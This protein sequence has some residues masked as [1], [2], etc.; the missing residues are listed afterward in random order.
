MHQ[1]IISHFNFTLHIF[2]CFN[3]NKYSNKNKKKAQQGDNPIFPRTVPVLAP[4]VS[5]PGNLRFPV[6]CSHYDPTNFVIF[7]SF[8]LC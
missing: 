6:G 7:Q 2:K 5:Y 4:K 1:E 3:V 8:Q